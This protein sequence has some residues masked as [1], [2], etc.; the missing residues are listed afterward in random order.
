MRN[1]NRH[2]RELERMLRA[3]RPQPP[4]E[5]VDDLLARI[6]PRRQRH[7]L[8]G[9]LVLALSLTLG[10][11]VALPAFGAVTYATS[12]VEQA[13]TAVTGAPTPASSVPTSARDQYTEQRR[14]CRNAVR[15]EHGAFH[16]QNRQNHRAHHA[17]NPKKAAHSTWHAQSNAAHRG[18]DDSYAA[19]RE[20]C[21]RIG[22]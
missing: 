6:E 3:A 16:E 4:Q 15:A 1:L 11:L 13:V 19:A 8:R 18:A 7:P 20:A 10:L 9:R 5:L 21:N 22:R 2:E 14:Q 12:A 17:T